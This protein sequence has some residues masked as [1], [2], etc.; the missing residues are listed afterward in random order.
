MTEEDLTMTRWNPDFFNYRELQ[1]I[2][3]ALI[4]WR[5]QIRVS[6][7]DE[8]FSEE[9]REKKKSFSMELGK[10]IEEIQMEKYKRG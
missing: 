4:Q 2:L 5:E 9:I 10:L 3:T 1:L 6:A 7:Y 8:R